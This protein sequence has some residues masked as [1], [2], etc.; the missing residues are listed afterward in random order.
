MFRGTIAVHPEKPKE[1]HNEPR[2][3]SCFKSGGTYNYIYISLSL[4][5][6]AFSGNEVGDQHGISPSVSGCMY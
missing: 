4:S 2:F 3:L 1:A 5:L 6:G